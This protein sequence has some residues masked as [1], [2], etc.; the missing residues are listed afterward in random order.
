MLSKRMLGRPLSKVNPEPI[1]LIDEIT[2]NNNSQNPHIKEKPEDCSSS[3]QEISSSESGSFENVK[4]N[5]LN[6]RYDSPGPDRLQYLLN[7]QNRSFRKKSVLQKK[8]TFYKKKNPSWLGKQFFSSFNP[9]VSAI[10]S[11]K[12]FVPVLPPLG[13]KIRTNYLLE[14]FQRKYHKTLKKRKLYTVDFYDQIS[15]FE[16]ELRR[17]LWKLVRDDFRKVL[18]LNFISEFCLI[19]SVYSL[20]LFSRAYAREKTE[21]WK[22]TFSFLGITSLTVLSIFI[23]SFT[24]QHQLSIQKRIGAKV[25]QSLRSIFFSKIA[26]SS[27]ATL[28]SIDQG[29]V[30]KYLFY[31]FVSIAKYHSTLSEAFVLPL[32]LILQIIVLYQFINWLALILIPVVSFM[33]LILARIEYKKMIRKKQLKKVAWSKTGLISEFLPHMKSVK[34]DSLEQFFLTKLFRVR[35]SEIKLLNKYN[36]YQSI[37]NFI[38]YLTPNLGSFCAIF[39]LFY[40]SKNF[41]SSAAFTVVTLMNRLYNP[42]KNAANFVETRINMQL[43]I[44][45]LNFF[46]NGIEDLQAELKK[47]GLIEVLKAGDAIIRIGRETKIQ[48]DDKRKEVKVLLEAITEADYD[49]ELELAQPQATDDKTVLKKT[50]LL[51]LKKQNKNLDLLRKSAFNMDPKREISI[52]HV[53]ELI[54]NYGSKIGLVGLENSGYL[55]FI[56]LLTGELMIGSRR[57]LGLEVLG[58]ISYLSLTNSIFYEGKTLRENIILNISFNKERYNFVLS[59]LKIDLEELPG[60][61]FVQLAEQGRN[62]SSSWLRKIILARFLYP[63]REIYILDDFIEETSLYERDLLFNIIFSGILQESTVL[64]VTVDQKFLSQSNECFVFEAGSIVERGSFTSLWE[65]ESSLLRIL[66]L[67]DND[68]RRGRKKRAS[69]FRMEP[70]MQETSSDSGTESDDEPLPDSKSRVEDGGKNPVLVSAALKYKRAF[71]KFWAVQLLRKQGQ[72]FEKEK[73]ESF[74]P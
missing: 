73:I 19:Y 51:L 70:I 49:E 65:N 40:T 55:N 26:K 30:S 61:D 7:D 28:E 31:E 18:L 27:R 8:S 25:G 72:V 11:G 63:S 24:K 59:E 60:R 53:P 50:I 38:L 62:L 20:Q 33:L 21:P 2:G 54:I 41:Q 34:I 4:K 36:L 29:F 13:A 3:F 17:T 16:N 66:C 56:N 1:I 32:N 58:R 5:D 42:L 45:S 47:F 9:I 57:K 68:K 74:S 39:I 43:G 69:V 23:G 6:V 67:R 10:L 44:R 12:N 35:G 15:N 14:K 22:N 48:N 46:L 52:L 71:K 37:S 64:F